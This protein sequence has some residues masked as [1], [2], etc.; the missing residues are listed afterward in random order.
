MASSSRSGAH[1]TIKSGRCAECRPAA[2]M[3]DLQIGAADDSQVRW[4]FVSRLDQHNVA[5]NKLLCRNFGL[6][7]LTQH[8]HVISAAPCWYNCCKRTYM[9]LHPAHHEHDM[10]AYFSS[11]MPSLC[12]SN[13]AAYSS[14]EA[15][16]Q[17]LLCA[18]ASATPAAKMPC[19]CCCSCS[20]TRK[21]CSHLPRHRS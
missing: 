1:I 14:I 3:A 7:A 11:L 12:V 2:C 5:R 20:P 8:L 21:L 16:C 4:H 18:L 9:L 19:C 13:R 6:P 17:L 15:S 10:P